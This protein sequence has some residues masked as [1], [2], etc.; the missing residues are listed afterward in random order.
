MHEVEW[1]HDLLKD[2]PDEHKQY[3]AVEHSILFLD[4]QP[5][6]A[7]MLLIESYQ[8]RGF[9]SQIIII[10]Q[11]G[12]VKIQKVEYIKYQTVNMLRAT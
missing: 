11:Y 2:V 12:K 4:L 8:L 6:A 10:T 9:L 7:P 5:R 1:D 3:Y